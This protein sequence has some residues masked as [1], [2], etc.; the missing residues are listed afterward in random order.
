M[1]TGA[2]PLHVG[3]SSIVVVVEVV[4]DADRLVAQVT[5]TQA[6]LQG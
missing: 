3:R 5:Q 2:R 1:R 4:D 6:V